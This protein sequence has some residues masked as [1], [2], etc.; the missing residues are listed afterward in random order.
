[1]NRNWIAVVIVVCQ[2]LIRLLI[3]KIMINLCATLICKVKPKQRRPYFKNQQNSSEIERNYSNAYNN[4]LLLLKNEI[5][6]IFLLFVTHLK[7]M[8]NLMHYMLK[9]NN[10]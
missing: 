10:V 2:W 9:E 5:L 8:R 7:S 1:M 6:I 4:N 3:F